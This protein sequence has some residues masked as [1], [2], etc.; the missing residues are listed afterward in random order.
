MGKFFS[1]LWHR[2]KSKTPPFFKKVRAFGGMMT[3]TGSGMIMNDLK[4]WKS[5]ATMAAGGLIISFIASLACT[6]STE[7]V[8][9]KVTT[10]PK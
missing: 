8:Q 3:A 4:Q 7:D 2:L 9:N 6:D 5:G 10:K 1:E